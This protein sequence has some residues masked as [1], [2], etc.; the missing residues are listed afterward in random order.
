[1]CPSAAATAAAAVVAAR[2]FQLLLTCSSNPY[3]DWF[4]ALA[5]LS[6]LDHIEPAGRQ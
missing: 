6:T 4:L 1:M 2:A 3:C 5:A